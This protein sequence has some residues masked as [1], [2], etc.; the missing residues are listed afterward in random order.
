L[1]AQSLWLRD[2][3]FGMA[4]YQGRIA[5]VRGRNETVSPTGYVFDAGA[6]GPLA[7][8]RGWM[9]VAEQE[10]LVTFVLLILLSV[11]I[12]S[13]LVTS[14]LGTGNTGLAG[15]LG[16]MVALQGEV[17]RERGG[18]WLEVVFLIGGS[19]VLFSTQLGIV[20]TVTRITGTIFYE[21]FGHRTRFWTLKRTFLFFLTLMVLASMAIITASWIGGE[22]LE[23][24]QPDFLVLIAGP[25]TIASMYALAIVIGVVNVR[26]LPAPL[27]PPGWKRWGMVWAAI[28]WGWFTA[29]QVSR[30]ILA[31]VD[32]PGAV[33][34]TI[35]LHPVRGAIYGLWVLSVLWFARVVLPAPASSDC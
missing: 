22:A 12:T 24:L 28:L 4:A 26:R 6:P 23:G 5:G 9:R 17:M 3:G 15:R 16:E 34:E 10:L 31:N 29:E 35:T 18:A 1:L 11:V 20:D 33:V 25:F 21:R 13:M 2:K 8:F 7:R 27:G 32:V 14:T 19:F 30:T